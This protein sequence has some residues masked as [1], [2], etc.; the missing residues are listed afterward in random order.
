MFVTVKTNSSL[1]VGTIVCHDSNNVW[2][3]ATSSDIAPLGI[4]KEETFLDEDNVRWGMVVL[5][6]TAFARAGENIV[7]QGGWF[8]CD[9]NGRAVIRQTEECGLIAPITRGSDV[10]LVDDLIL[11]HIR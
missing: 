7:K 4:I 6:G 8:G 11:V 3:Q 9:D 2:R 5:S 1:P 10:P